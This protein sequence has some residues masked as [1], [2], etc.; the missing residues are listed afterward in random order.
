MEAVAGAARNQGLD[1]E[2]MEDSEA[3]MRQ[4]YEENLYFQQNQKQLDPQAQQMALKL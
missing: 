2:D 3:I 1:M 4:I